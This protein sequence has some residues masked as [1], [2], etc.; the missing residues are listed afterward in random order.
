MRP[1]TSGS[2]SLLAGRAA[3]VTGAAQGI[4]LAI[5]TT[6]ASHGASVVIAD[7]KRQAAEGAAAQLSES[8]RTPRSIATDVTDQQQMA[9]AAQ[10]CIDTAKDCSYLSEEV[11]DNLLSRYV[12]IGNMLDSMIKK[13]AW[14]CH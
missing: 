9:N 3:I 5:A 2:T 10:H 6:L 4:G 11:A 14:F 13:S 12:S 1:T 8:G 7:I